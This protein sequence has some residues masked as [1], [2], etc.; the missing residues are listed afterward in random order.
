MD[1]NKSNNSDLGYYLTKSEL[2]EMEQSRENLEN[3]YNSFLRD[4][5]K[6]SFYNIIFINDL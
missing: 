6:I 5:Q 4:I 3:Y 1:L 2:N